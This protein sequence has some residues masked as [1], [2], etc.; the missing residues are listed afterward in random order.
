MNEDDGYDDASSKTL[1]ERFEDGEPI[2]DIIRG[3]FEQSAFFTMEHLWFKFWWVTIG[4]GISIIASYAFS[5]A[6]NFVFYEL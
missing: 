6:L 2:M 1:E 4:V 3:Y 5:M